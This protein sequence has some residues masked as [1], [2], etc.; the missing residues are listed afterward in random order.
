MKW[1]LNKWNGIKRR[2]CG[3]LKGKNEGIEN[4][5]DVETIVDG[6]KRLGQ[7]L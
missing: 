7:V 6:P 5:K 1:V 3:M 2:W 4:K